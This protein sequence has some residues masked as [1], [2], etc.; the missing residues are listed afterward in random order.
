MATITVTTRI[1]E[2]PLA[3][4]PMGG[5]QVLVTALD[6]RPDTAFPAQLHELS[7]RVMT[8]ST[9]RPLYIGCLLKVEYLD[10][11][12]LGEVISR[13]PSA[14]KA[15]QHRTMVK[16]EHSLHRETNTRVQ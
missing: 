14:T 2:R 11:L 15:G 4:A 16:L 1:A 8:L 10:D 3:Q 6:E 5:T 13:S 12:W 7:Q 9:Q